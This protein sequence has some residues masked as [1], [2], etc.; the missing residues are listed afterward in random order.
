MA[1]FRVLAKSFINNTIFVEGDVVDFDGT[2][3]SN[4]EPYEPAQKT[5][6]KGAAVPAHGAEPGVEAELFEEHLT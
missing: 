3:G 2:P 1:K 5:R 6:G 4:L